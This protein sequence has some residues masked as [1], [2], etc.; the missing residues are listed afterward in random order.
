M[1]VDGRTACGVTTEEY[2][3]WIVVRSL[4]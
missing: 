4:G 3:I 1:D 2:E